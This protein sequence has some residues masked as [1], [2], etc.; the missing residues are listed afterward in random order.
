M[1]DQSDDNL[2]HRAAWHGATEC[3]QVLIKHGCDVRRKN[4]LGGYMPI[5]YAV[6]Q[7]HF[8][9]VEML[10]NNE[11]SLVNAQTNLGSTPL[12][13]AAEVN[14]KEMVNLLLSF[15]TGAV[16]ARRH[17]GSKPIDC[18]NDAEIKSMIGKK[19]ADNKK[20]CFGV[21]VFLFFVFLI[22]PRIFSYFT[23][24]FLLLLA[25]IYIFRSLSS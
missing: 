20:I 11:H 4:G 5:H 18:T 14:N 22:L 2:L 13:F 16:L 7:K 10:L 15:N 1:C 8:R 3:V 19:D 25:T 6:K 17:D 12:H 23:I 21:F 24:S 9:I